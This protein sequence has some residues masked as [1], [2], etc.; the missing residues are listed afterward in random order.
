MS[1]Y[2]LSL[3]HFVCKHTHK[4]HAIANTLAKLKEFDDFKNENIGTVT[5]FLEQDV[6]S[7]THTSRIKTGL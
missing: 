7:C 4:Q 2:M 3:M 6:T 1:Q 5:K